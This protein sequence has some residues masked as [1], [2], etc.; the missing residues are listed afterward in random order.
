MKLRVILLSLLKVAV[1]STGLAACGGGSAGKLA[2]DTPILPYKAPDIDD[3]T[4]DDG[5][6]QV[7][8]PPTSGDA[9][10]AAGS[11]AGSASAAQP[12]K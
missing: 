8:E 2:V 1:I 5:F 7:G 4:G 9:A 6:D 3:I 11:A 10:P 12:T